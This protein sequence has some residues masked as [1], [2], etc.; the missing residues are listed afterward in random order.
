MFSFQN[1]KLLCAKIANIPSVSAI[2]D[3][4]LEGMFFLAQSLHL[5]TDNIGAF[6]C[7]NIRFRVHKRDLVLSVNWAQQRS[8]QLGPAV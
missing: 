3:Y 8:R 4:N 2:S 1:E 5:F 7:I 6:N